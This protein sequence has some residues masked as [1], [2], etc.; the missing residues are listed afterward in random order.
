MQYRPCQILSTRHT[1]LSIS[2]S[3]FHKNSEAYEGMHHP[4][5]RE[6]TIPS[7]RSSAPPSSNPLGRLWVQHDLLVVSDEVLRVSDVRRCR[8]AAAARRDARA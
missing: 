1:L 6:A 8:A 3:S 7:A 5:A 2:Q 4:T